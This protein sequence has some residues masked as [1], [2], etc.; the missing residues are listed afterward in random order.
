MVK[1]LDTSFKGKALRQPNKIS[2]RT[3][4]HCQRQWKYL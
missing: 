2:D 4:C 1:A 3:T